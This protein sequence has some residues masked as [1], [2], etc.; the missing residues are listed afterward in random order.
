MEQG[1]RHPENPGRPRDLTMISLRLGT[2]ASLLR[3]PVSRSVFI[4]VRPTHEC[5]RE[6]SSRPHKHPPPVN[7]KY[8]YKQNQHSF[9]VIKVRT[10]WTGG[11]PHPASG[12]GRPDA[13]ALTEEAATTP[14]PTQGHGRHERP[15]SQA[16]RGPAHGSLCWLL[17]A[18]L[19]PLGRLAGPAPP[20]K[21]TVG[22]ECGPRGPLGGAQSHL[23]RIWRPRGYSPQEDTSRDHKHA[24]RVR[25]GHFVR[26]LRSAHLQEPT[27][28]HNCS[29]LRPA[30]LQR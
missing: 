7:L 4:H 10:C 12:Q 29:A 20:G 11:V 16:T 1:I 2:M 14:T 3:P 13:S 19:A 30:R 28:G 8:N 5:L 25:H 9:H 27:D 24:F 17:T 18:R 15:G 22:A 6:L 21:S 26:L 23:G